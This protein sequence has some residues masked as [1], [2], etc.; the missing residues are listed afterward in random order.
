MTIRELFREFVVAKHRTEDQY[1]RDMHLA[2]QGVRIFV[3][4]V[5][6][7]GYRVPSLASLLNISA[8]SQSFDDMEAQLRFLSKQTGFPIR[9]H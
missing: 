9:E 4:S 6:E 1:R 2:W 5:K 8:P 7:K 3:M